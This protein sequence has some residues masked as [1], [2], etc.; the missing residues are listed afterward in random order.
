M[1]Y[2]AFLRCLRTNCKASHKPVY[3]HYVI[4]GIFQ[5][6][7]DSYFLIILFCHKN[8]AE[9]FPFN[10]VLLCGIWNQAKS[11][12]SFA[13]QSLQPLPGEQL[14][15]GACISHH[16]WF[17]P[18][19]CSSAEHGSSYPG[20]FLLMNRLFCRACQLPLWSRPLKAAMPFFTPP[21]QELPGSKVQ[22]P[23]LRT[24]ADFG[25]WRSSLLIR[26]DMNLKHHSYSFFFF[27]SAQVAA[28]PDN[29]VCFRNGFR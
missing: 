22:R 17:D 24:S 2:L 16:V 15:A 29:V 8:I 6:T 20:A 23:G 1:K 9:F 14:R 4:R 18:L 21:R 7:G 25:A 13:L 3:K 11:E 5:T 12:H 28:R 19:V 10:N 26:K 27:F